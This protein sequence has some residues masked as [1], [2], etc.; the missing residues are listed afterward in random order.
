MS[1]RMEEVIGYKMFDGKNKHNETIEL[2]KNLDM[3]Y[4]YLTN[5]VK[6]TG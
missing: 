4:C 3:N 6:K 1:K 2:H 5:P